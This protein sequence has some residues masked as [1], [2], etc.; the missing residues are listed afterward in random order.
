[1]PRDLFSQAERGR[2]TN[3]V[4]REAMRKRQIF[5]P[6][7]DGATKS[8]TEMALDERHSVYREFVKSS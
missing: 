6:D 7:T 1:M 5:D 3:M 8:L 4:I 2:E